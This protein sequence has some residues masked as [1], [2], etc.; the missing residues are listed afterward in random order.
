MFILFWFVFHYYEKRLND[1]A[2]F[3][4]ASHFYFLDVILRHRIYSFK[5]MN[6]FKT[7]ETLCYI[8]PQKG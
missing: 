6:I 4:Y 1:L 5:G 3:K 7:F 8:I 2:K